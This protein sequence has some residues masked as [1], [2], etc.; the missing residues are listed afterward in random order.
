MLTSLGLELPGASGGSGAEGPERKWEMLMREA[1][2]CVG[3]ILV[4][5]GA[6]PTTV[7]VII[8]GECRIVKGKPHPQA[9]GKK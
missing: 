4:E 8:E 2:Y 9:T 5:E 1:R 3:S 6:P 7:F